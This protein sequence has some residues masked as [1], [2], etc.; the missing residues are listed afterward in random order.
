MKIIFAWISWELRKK[1]RIFQF[2]IFE[3]IQNF[4]KIFPLGNPSYEKDTLKLFFKVLDHL[5]PIKPLPSH[6]SYKSIRNLKSDQP[7]FS[8]NQMTRSK[9][10]RVKIDFTYISWVSVSLGWRSIDT[11][12]S[13]FWFILHSTILAS[14]FYRI[15]IIIIL[16]SFMVPTKKNI[17]TERTGPE[18]WLDN[19]LNYLF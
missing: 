2:R 6:A 1:Y 8:T 13:Y 16:E 15:F 9:N 7:E 19:K 12:F 4:I 18:V 10:R 5:P 11:R 14:L 17:W 3:T